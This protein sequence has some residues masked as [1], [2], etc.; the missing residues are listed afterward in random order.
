MMTES[1]KN[2]LELAREHASAHF[3]DREGIMAATANALIGTNNLHIFLDR[4]QLKEN[5]KSADSYGSTPRRMKLAEVKRK[6]DEGF[7]DDPNYL[8]ELA[9]K[10]IRKLGL[11]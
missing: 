7:Y 6:I 1:E 4:A 2:R 11:E 3:Y 5:G 9:E 10:L 8:A